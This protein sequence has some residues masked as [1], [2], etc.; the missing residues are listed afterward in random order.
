MMWAL[1]FLFVTVLWVLFLF[2]GVWGPGCWDSFCILAG[3]KEIPLGLGFLFS[4]VLHFLSSG[5]TCFGCVD[6]DAWFIRTQ[7][8]PVRH[9]E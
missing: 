2:M 4:L 8:L 1:I 9:V 5:F 3:G 7:L 6:E